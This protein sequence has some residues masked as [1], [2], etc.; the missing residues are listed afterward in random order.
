MT[1]HNRETLLALALRGGPITVRG[2]VRFIRPVWQM[3]LILPLWL[4]YAP[5]RAFVD[6][7]DRRL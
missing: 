3:I 7:V 4:I 5:L 2:K 6:F 1:Q